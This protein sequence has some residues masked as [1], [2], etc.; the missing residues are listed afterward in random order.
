MSTTADGVSLV[1][2]VHNL[3]DRIDRLMGDWSSALR[4]TERETELI[5]VDD[6]STDGTADKAERAGGGRV[7]RHDYQKGFGACIRTAIPEAKFPIFGYVGSDYPYS[8]ADLKKL[9]TAFGK[10][11]EEMK[12]TVDVVCGCRTGIPVPGF[13]K[14]MGKVQR[15]FYSY[16]LGNPQEPLP[17]WLGLGEHLF[18][19]RT[20]WYY[21][22]PFRDVNCAFK[23]F[24]KSRLETI[25]IQ[26]DDD[27]VH[28]E[29]IA[30]M[31]FLTTLM[32]EI[33]LSPKSHPIPPTVR[34]GMRMVRSKPMFRRPE[35]E[36]AI[37][38]A[39]VT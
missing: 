4:Q 8:P 12:M 37:E 1:L 36:P 11:N 21:G 38:I 24:K 35:P 29:L 31:T 23:L 39:A 17:G 13:W 34:S 9:L 27:G 5:I 30:K 2:P 10:F 32:D 7:I 19:L 33:P 26:C 6:G 28:T 3:A 20:S 25:P 15:F 18:N 16:G 22:N 14:W